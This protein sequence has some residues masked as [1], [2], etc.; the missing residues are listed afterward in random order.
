MTDVIE[1]LKDARPPADGPS[2]EVIERARASFVRRRP[3]RRPR[4][5][6][7]AVP[8][9][10]V[11]VAAVVLGVTL[12]D[13]GGDRASASH[14]EEVAEA[15][16]RLLVDLPGWRVK[17]TDRFSVEYGQ[18]TLTNGRQELE[19]QWLPEDE[20]QL[21][22]EKRVAELEDLGTAP[23]GESEAR[24]FRYPG[25]NEYFAV[26]LRGD[27]TVEARG[28]AAD[29]E[30]FKATIA[31]LHEVDIATWLTALPR[32]SNFYPGAGLPETPR[33]SRVPA[34]AEMSVFK[35]P[36]TAADVL[37][38]RY[39]ASLEPLPCPDELRELGR[40]PY[41]AHVGDESRLLLSGLG[42]QQE[43]IYAWPMDD[44][45]VC[46]GRARGGGSICSPQFR[47]GIRAEI[48][49]VDPPKVDGA[50]APGAILGLIPDDVVAVDVVVLGM[51]RPA[52][53][54]NNAFFYE[55]PDVS[56]GLSTFDAV[57]VTLRDGTVLSESVGWE[58]EDR[59]QHEGKV[60]PPFCRG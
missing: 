10:A 38:E 45:S 22:A 50:G 19:L 57:V 27:Y 43:S 31:A 17:R 30:A 6:L 60:P 33:R 55:L 59:P 49:G 28:R 56:C 16:P 13:G 18:V 3:R 32:T 7:W 8:A 52:T 53:I 47:K 42:V 5:V 48:F 2:A 29:A 51:R 12:A 1:L 11:G 20:Y 21:E 24:L 25:T 14:R 36:R 44:G 46:L 34:V 58:G 26:W 9:F 15:A 41:P 40:C 4:R 39:A 23:A 54:G 37:P 35:R